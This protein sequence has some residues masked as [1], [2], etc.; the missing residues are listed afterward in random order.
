MLRNVAKLLF[1]GTR[2]DT[3]SWYVFSFI[4]LF[5][6]VRA[7]LL[8]DISIL[9]RYTFRYSLDEIFSFDLFATS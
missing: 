8:R 6:E 5:D 2:L 1:W 3:Q 4:R 7:E 9:H